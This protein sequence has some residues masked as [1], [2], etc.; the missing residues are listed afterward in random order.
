MSSDR[1]LNPQPMRACIENITINYVIVSSEYALQSHI[2]SSADIVRH[3]AADNCQPE[4]PKFIQDRT[5]ASPAA[6][7]RDVVQDDH[8]WVEELEGIRWHRRTNEVAC[9]EKIV[10]IVDLCGFLLVGLMAI[11]QYI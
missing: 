5:H 7:P 11:K 6:L 9:M 3:R 4:H 10:K 8:N 1:N 2:I